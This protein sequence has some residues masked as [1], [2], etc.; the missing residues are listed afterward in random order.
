MS[1]NNKVSTNTEISKTEL[2][3]T[4]NM[5]LDE[6]KYETVSSLEIKLSSINS[7]K[8][9]SYYEQ[10]SAD[11]IKLLLINEPEKYS[12]ASQFTKNIFSM[13]LEGDNILQIKK[14]WDAILY[15]F[16]KYVSTNKS[17]TVYKYLKAEHQN[18][19]YFLLPPE[20]H[21]KLTT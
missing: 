7:N 8:P 2:E 4:M 15:D 6:F 18:T 20:T 1:T 5:L 10:P 14:L 16:C 13:N 11:I 3:A 21:N 9:S 17:C 12:H 19:S